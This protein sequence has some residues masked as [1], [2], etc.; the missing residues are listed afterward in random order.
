MLYTKIII[1]PFLI[2]HVPT[3][4]QQSKSEILFFIAGTVLFN[5]HT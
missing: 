5:M 2:T 4:L 1:E 3:L